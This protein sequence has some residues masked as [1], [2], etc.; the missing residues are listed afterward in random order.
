MS[1]RSS[2]RAPPESSTC[3]PTEAT[4]NQLVF[5]IYC[6][7]LDITWGNNVS[8]TSPGQTARTSFL[9]ASRAALVVIKHFSLPIVNNTN[10]NCKLVPQ[11][12]RASWG[13]YNFL[14]S[15]CNTTL[16]SAVYSIY[17]NEIQTGGLLP[18]AGKWAACQQLPVVG[19]YVGELPP[20]AISVMVPN[21]TVQ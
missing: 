18:H 4:K 21:Q 9:Q 20:C 19:L 2:S 11:N 1:F 8:N 3:P 12:L 5:P 6:W 15:T 10:K 7:L 13:H 17:G 14:Q 16:I